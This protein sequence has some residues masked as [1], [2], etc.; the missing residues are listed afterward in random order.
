MRTSFAVLVASVAG[1]LVGGLAVGIFLFLWLDEETQQ[2][3]PVVISSSGERTTNWGKSS[4]E[5]IGEGRI[6]TLD[7][8]LQVQSVLDST[9]LASDFDQ[10]VSLYVLLARADVSDLER[11]IS[12]SYAVTPR[13]QRIAALSIIFGRYAA[14]DPNKA[15]ERALKISQVSKSERS[16]LVRSIFNE[17]IVQDLDA[18]VAAIQELPQPLKFAAANSMIWR[19]DFLNTDQRVQL[20]EQIGPSDT[21]IANAVS[22]IHIESSRADPRQAFYELIRDT[23]RTTEGNR[24]LL[25]IAMQWYEVEGP[26]VLLEVYESIENTS[27]RRNLI[28]N[29]IYY[30]IPN[31]TVE[32]ESVLRFVSEFPNKTDAQQLTENVFISWSVVAPQEAFES[33]LEFD[34]QFVSHY[35]RES[36]LR[37]W[38]IRD[39][40]GLFA[41]ASS[42]PRKYRATAFIAALGQMALERPETAIGFARNLDTR[43]LQLQARDEIVQEWSNVDAKSAFEWL[44]KDGFN[45]V[46]EPD[47]SVWWNAYSRY[48]H[49]DFESARRFAEE[50]QGEQKN[51]LIE[52][53]VRHLI[54]MDLD[55]AIE[56]LPKVRI[57]RRESLQF[58]IGLEMART[59]PVEALNFGKTISEDRRGRYYDDLLGRWANRDFFSLHQNIHRV[60]DAYLGNAARDLLRINEDNDHLSAREVRKLEDIVAANPVTNPYGE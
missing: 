3:V 59:R 37:S 18:A 17:W 43:G 24:E 51:Q 50:Y 32:P 22:N 26:K 56:Y 46:E 49:E 29:L 34:D 15:L 4:P 28:D 40:D 30:G 38:A 19:S 39:A 45:S 14:V 31:K 58:S 11:F 16:N 9:K 53:V 10:S 57:S 12:E 52:A 1:V 23:T 33:S 13:N 41:E 21:W 6:S 7:P 20:A 55:Q 42:M 35:T 8:I 44:M 2:S 47:Y 25:N 5:V 36:I 60:P 54:D 27:T 48:L